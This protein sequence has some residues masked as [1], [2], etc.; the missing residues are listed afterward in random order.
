MS[1]AIAG[2]RRRATVCQ[3]MSIT[4]LHLASTHTHDRINPGRVSAT[5][6]ARVDGY[7]RMEVD[8]F[9]GSCQDSGSLRLGQWPTD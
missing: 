6:T 2:S 4:F 7:R 1:L 9:A 5:C 8:Y 3:P